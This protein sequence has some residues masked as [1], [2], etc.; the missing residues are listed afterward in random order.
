[1]FSTHC[2]LCFSFLQRDFR[3]NPAHNKRKNECLAHLRHYHDWRTSRLTSFPTS[4]CGSSS[5]QVPDIGERPTNK[6]NM[7]FSILPIPARHPH[8]TRNRS[9][10]EPTHDSMVERVHCPKWSLDL[11]LLRGLPL[12]TRWL[13]GQCS[14]GG[15]RPELVRYHLFLRPGLRRMLRWIYESS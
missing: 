11:F 3:I 8:K 15:A 10:L 6:S 9:I 7:A 14:V 1:V 12:E 13:S 2:A 5:L 4:S